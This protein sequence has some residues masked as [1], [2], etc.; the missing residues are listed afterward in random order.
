MILPSVEV[1]IS[2]IRYNK[3]DPLISKQSCN[4][5]KVAIHISNII[6]IIPLC[7]IKTWKIRFRWPWWY[8]YSMSNIK[9]DLEKCALCF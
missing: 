3:N 1:H 4:Q 8:A 5:Y 2:V 6:N 9:T 7:Y